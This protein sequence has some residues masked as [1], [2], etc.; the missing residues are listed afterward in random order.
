MSKIP[1]AIFIAFFC[2]GYSFSSSPTQSQNG[3]QSIVVGETSKWGFTASCEYVD[4]NGNTKTLTCRGTVDA[5]TKIG[6]NS[7]AKAELSAEVR[8][9]GGKTS[10]MHSISISVSKQ[11]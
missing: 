10:S 8:R 4:S 3:K 6:A 2:V 11:F 5:E 7:S 9:K 1:L